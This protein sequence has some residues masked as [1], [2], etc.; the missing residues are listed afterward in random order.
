VTSIEFEF[1]L[2]SLRRSNAASFS[3]TSSCASYLG[4]T[5]QA[6]GPPR[7]LYVRAPFGKDSITSLEYVFD[8]RKLPL[9]AP[10][11]R[12]SLSV[13]VWLLEPSTHSRPAFFRDQ[14]HEWAI[15]QTVPFEVAFDFRISTQSVWTLTTLLT[16]CSRSLH[17]NS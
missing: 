9:K 12:E 15:K 3:H 8:P 2:S 17:L 1:L 14:S 6:L 16:N 7:L 11:L 5:Q 4:A 13:R 10:L